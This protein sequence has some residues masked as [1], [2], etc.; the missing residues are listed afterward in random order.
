MPPRYNSD[1]YPSAYHLPTPPKVTWRAKLGALLSRWRYYICAAG[2]LLTVLI[3][4]LLTGGSGSPKNASPNKQ[5]ATTKATESS[6]VRLIAT[7][8]TIAH[9]VLNA[10]AKQPSGDYDYYQFM[11]LM[12]P[13]FD[14][15][16][17]RFCNQAVPGGGEKFGISGY[18]VFNSPLQVAR[19]L[20][21]LGCN[22][23]NTGTNHTFDRGQAVIDAELDYWDTLPNML[24]VAGANRTA[25]EQA[26]PRTFTVKGVKFAFL[27]YTTYSNTSP[28]N[29]Y[30]LNVFDAATAQKDITAARQSA[31]IVLVSMRW[32]TE[33]SSSI[34]DHQKQLAQQLADWG[35]D[36]V[37]GHGPHVLEPVQKLIGNG[38]RQT[39]VWYSIGNFLNAQE[40]IE[41]LVSGLV[42]VDIDIKTKQIQ[43]PAYLPTYMHYE[44]TAEQK[45]KEDLLARHDFTIVP[46]DQATSLLARSQNNTTVAAQTRRVTEL[47]NTNTKVKMLTSKTY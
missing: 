4:V 32:G 37:L 7:G 18:P 41:S 46:L 10:R 9:D 6:R 31:D 13:Y 29:S 30:G 33:Y 40:S 5:N 44:W 39:L 27:S 22:V 45:A 3:I 11:K 17:V 42:V 34:N 1:M 19:D 38:G 21:R 25:Q 2:I 8:D 36:V 12:K 43:E 26:K 15:A 28:A 47:L 20:N 23:V 14:K 16:D 35:A 24:A